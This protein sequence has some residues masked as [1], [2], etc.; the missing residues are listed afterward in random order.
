MT[1]GTGSSGVACAR[2]SRDHGRRKFV[3]IDVDP[4]QVRIAQ[5]RIA[6]ELG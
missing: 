2:V 3:G 6:A 5:T 4:D 1:C